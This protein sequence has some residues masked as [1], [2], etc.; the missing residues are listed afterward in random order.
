[1]LDWMGADDYMGAF[2]YAG[3]PCYLFQAKEIAGP[4]GTETGAHNKNYPPTKCPSI[5]DQGLH[6]R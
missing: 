6:Q 5:T 4:G 2:I 1:M 3:Q